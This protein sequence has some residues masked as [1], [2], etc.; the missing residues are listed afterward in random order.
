[1]HACVRVRAYV[2]RLRCSVLQQSVGDP[3]TNL[4]LREAMIPPLRSV[5][6]TSPANAHACVHA[7]TTTDG[8]FNVTHDEL[9]FQRLPWSVASAATLGG[10]TDS[11]YCDTCCGMPYPG[12]GAYPGR[13]GIR[14]GS[15]VLV[16]HGLVL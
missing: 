3:R 13:E 10:C 1:M 4:L 14:T 12:T 16:Q 11:E 7:H 6:R 15:C 2:R 9:L 5:Q 8:I